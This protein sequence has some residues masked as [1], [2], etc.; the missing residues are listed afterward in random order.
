MT[1]DGTN[2]FSTGPFTIDGSSTS[3]C[4]CYRLDVAYDD[5]RGDGITTDSYYW[6]IGN[7]C[8]SFAPDPYDGSSFRSSSTDANDEVRVVPNPAGESVSLHIAQQ[9]DGAKGVVEIR[10]IDG[11][12]V[13][14]NTMPL[15][16][17]LTI[18]SPIERG[19]YLY[20]VITNGKVFSGKFIKL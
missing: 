16:T 10:T 11:R 8:P 1:V 13:Y 17:V 7:D 18:D 12:L 20:L 14:Q 6:K 3:D 2:P 9:Y 4:E 19:T 15:A 5:G